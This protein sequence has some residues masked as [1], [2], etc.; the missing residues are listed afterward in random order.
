MAEVED[1]LASL[2]SIIEKG[3]GEKALA[4]VRKAGKLTARER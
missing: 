2:R 1:E 3:G 4:K